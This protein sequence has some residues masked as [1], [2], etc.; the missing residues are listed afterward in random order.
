[1]KDPYVVLCVDKNASDEEVKKA[2]RELARK[3]HPD[4]YADNPL[5]DLAAEKM[6][7]INDAYDA[8]MNMRRNASSSSDGKTYTSYEF[9]DVRNMITR[10]QIEQAQI[11]LDGVPIEK[12]TA[13]WHFL[14]GTVQY[15]RGH[16]DGAYTSFATATRM[17]PSNAEYAEAFRRI[18]RQASG[19]FRNP[20]R[21]SPNMGGM[22]ACDCCSSLICAD[23]C[24]ECMGGDLISCC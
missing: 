21:S 6:K 1:M 12:R 15:K 8:I 9:A 18:Q 4:S 13:E 10:G 5:S 11:V 20:Y 23:C 17:D 7:E 24:C 19:G 16:F 14:S 3:Y 2:Y 22:D